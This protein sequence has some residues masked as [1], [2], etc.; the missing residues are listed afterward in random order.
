[1][2]VPAMLY[3]VCRLVA[4]LVCALL[5]LLGINQVLAEMVH[6]LLV[7]ANQPRSAPAMNRER[8]G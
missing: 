4:C 8:G 6:V 7:T 5:R 2:S 3:R 1:M